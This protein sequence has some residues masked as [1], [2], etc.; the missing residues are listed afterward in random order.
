MDIIAAYSPAF[1]YD[2]A[3]LWN[4]CFAGTHNFSPIGH[5]EFRTRVTARRVFEPERFYVSLSEGKVV[6]VVHMPEKHFPAPGRPASEAEKRDAT[7]AALAIMYTHPR[8]RKKG[9]TR[10]LVEKA[11]AEAA[12]SGVKEVSIGRRSPFYDKMYGAYRQPGIHEGNARA[13][14]L[15]TRFG[16]RE[17]SAQVLYES[18]MLVVAPKPPVPRVP[19]TFALRRRGADTTIVARSQGVEVARISYDRMDGWSEYTGREKC[20]IYDLYVSNGHR[21]NGIGS[22]LFCLALSRIRQLYKACEFQAGEGQEFAAARRLAGKY[23]FRV[24]SRWLDFA[25]HLG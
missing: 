5:R 9:V 21:R 18:D 7:K 20:A 1:L 3:A 11:L 23:G 22:A 6:A 13:I 16:F 15:V 14:G 2:V 4:V 12:A 8:A 24:H 17:T 25:K 19:V 10:Q